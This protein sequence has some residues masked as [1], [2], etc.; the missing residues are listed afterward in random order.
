MFPA[1]LA[2]LN[3]C[4]EAW[5]LDRAYMGHFEDGALVRHYDAAVVDELCSSCVGGGS[6]WLTPE[7]G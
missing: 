1:F 4:D 5:G 7:S 3:D 2:I 6:W